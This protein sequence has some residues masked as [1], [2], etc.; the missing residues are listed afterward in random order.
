[1]RC[2]RQLAAKPATA[3]DLRLF[4]LARRTLRL[5]WTR[6]V[7]IRHVRLICDRLIFPPAQLE[8]FAAEQKQNE[9]YDNL[10]SVIDRIRQR[11]GREAVQVGR[12]MA[13]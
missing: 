7:R 2:A 3:N 1:M 9:K 11:F 10:I 5:A 6:R 4:E 12:T 8:L 13:A